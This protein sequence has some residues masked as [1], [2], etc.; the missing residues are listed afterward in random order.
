MLLTFPSLKR[1][2]C[3]KKKLSRENRSSRVK[4]LL[5][6][7]VNIK[8]HSSHKKDCLNLPSQP[9]KMCPKKIASIPDRNK[10]EENS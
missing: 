9:K 10:K 4:T 1:R 7:Y 8:S 5:Y 2:P 3:V 6:R